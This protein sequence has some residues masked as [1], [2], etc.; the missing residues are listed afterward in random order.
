MLKFLAANFGTIIIAAILL[1]IVVLIVINLVGK[2]KKG[3]STCGCGCS[4]CPSSDMCHKK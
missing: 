3:Q 2:K 4:D 1:L